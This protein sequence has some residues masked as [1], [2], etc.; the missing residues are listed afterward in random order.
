MSSP[1]GKKWVLLVSGSKGWADYRHQADVCRAYQIMHRQGILD[2]QIVVMMYDDIAD[3]PENNSPRIIKNEPLGGDVYEGV[4][5]DYT[6]ADVTSSNFPAVLSGNKSKLSTGNASSRKVIQSNSKDTIFVYMT[7]HGGS[8]LFSFPAAHDVLHSEDLVNTLT[9]MAD[10]HK[11]VQLVIFVESC[12][13]GSML[14]NL[15]HNI[16][17]YGITASP[18]DKS[19]YA[20]FHDRWRGTYL[21]DVYS[22]IW[23]DFVER[24]ELERTT[25]EE[26]FKHLSF[27]LWRQN[28]P[29]CQQYGNTGLS[30]LPLSSVLGTTSHERVVFARKELRLTHLTVSHEVRHKIYQGKI[31]SEKQGAMKRDLETAYEEYK[32]KQRSMA[33]GVEIFKVHCSKGRCLVPKEQRELTSQSDFKRVTE[34][35]REIF[36]DLHDEMLELTLPVPQ[37]LL[38]V[39]EFNVDVEHIIEGI[40][41]MRTVVDT[42]IPPARTRRRHIRRL[43]RELSMPVE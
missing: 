17:V 40:A 12:Y 35:F 42:F 10:M 21:A 23:M 6:K 33:K 15:P 43:R 24:N 28:L 22:A 8:G 25:F 7:N 1:F 16:P 27:E 34:S 18:P 4:P 37:V 3:N 39:M 14:K 26:L 36:W 29:R 13:S 31:E 32:K 5:K 38:E 20:A 41:L 30:K 2:E 19:S 9:E 11:F